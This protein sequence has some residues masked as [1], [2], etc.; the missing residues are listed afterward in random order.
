MT[1]TTTRLTAV[2]GLCAAAAGAI[3]IGVQIGH[4]HLDAT[5]IQT[6]EMAV[7]S[8]LKLLMAV[9]ALVGISGMYLSQVPRNGRLGLAGFVVLA[10]GYLCIVGTAYASALVLPTVAA[11]D[12]GY[13]NDMFAAS[14]GGSPFGD[15]GPPRSDE[16]CD[17]PR[18]AAMDAWPHPRR[19]ARTDPLAGS[20]A[21]R[22]P[23]Q[24]DPPRL[25][26]VA[27]PTAATP[28]RDGRPHRW[29]VGT[30]GRNGCAAGGLGQDVGAARR[31]H[32]TRGDLGALA[33]SVA[34]GQ[35]LPALA[36]PQ[37][38]CSAPC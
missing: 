2:A 4:P 30:R 15:I 1:I 21:L 11:T 38:H 14:T 16:A 10:T 25:P 18:R 36:R 13:V 20:A 29:P 26:D 34:L 24:R 8:T 22:R 17:S 5:S 19:P 7:R 6:T 3:F 37:W 31:A 27:I 9:L 32:G 33:H 23:R 12:P 28:A 35:G